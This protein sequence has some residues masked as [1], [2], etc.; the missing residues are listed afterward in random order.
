MAD[1]E[2][3]TLGVP[4]T[5]MFLGVAST[6]FFAFQGCSSYFFGIADANRKGC[7]ERLRWCFIATTE[8]ILSKWKYVIASGVE[9]L[10]GTAIAMGPSI[11]WPKR[12]E[13][14]REYEGALVR[15]AVWGVLRSGLGSECGARDRRSADFIP[16]KGIQMFEF[17]PVTCLLL[18]GSTKRN[19]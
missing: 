8:L 12:H 4:M 19:R 13:A 10:G 9:P 2:I 16:E 6:R 14:M 5:T 7:Q 17:D 15:G 1:R 18:E 11:S 3:K